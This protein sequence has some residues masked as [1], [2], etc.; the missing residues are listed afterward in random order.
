[1]TMESGRLVAETEAPAST[2]ALAWFDQIRSFLIAQDLPPEPPVYDVLWRY[3]RDENHDLSLAIDR[4][5]ADR[6]L[7]LPTLLD[8]R[9][10]YVDG[11]STGDVAELVEVVHGQARALT[12]TIEVGQTNLA[13][14]DRALT[15][16]SSALSTPLEAAALAELLENLG[17]ATN[18]MQAANAKLAADLAVA[19]TEARTLSVKLGAAQRA[20][21]TDQ[22]TGLLNRR[23]TIALIEQAQAEARSAGKPLSLALMDIDNFKRVNDRFGHSLGDDV[24]RF[25]A[26]HLASQSDV[27]GGTVGR[28]GGE[29]FVA[30]LPGQP[31]A[32]ATATIDQIRAR[33]A[34]QIIRNAVDGSSLGRVTFSA[35][36]T[37]D[38]PNDTASTIL[39]RADRALYTAKRMGR[40]RVVP[41]RG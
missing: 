28:L 38:T 35:G 5:I 36:V 12:E 21:I 33:L 13:Q 29:E 7:D 4:V 10:K 9:V 30:V 18:T 37:N 6:Q 15:H 32:M 3:V 20:A 34:G 41:D 1:M 16:G 39:E 17:E 26:D 22:L 11:I 40:D 27:A 14:Y 23:G 2:A 24:L 8:L 25:V 31:L 19:V